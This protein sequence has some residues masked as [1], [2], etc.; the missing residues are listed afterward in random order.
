MPMETNQ[1]YIEKYSLDSEQE[2]RKAQAELQIAV[3]MNI[4]S[5]TEFSAVEERRVQKNETI[6]KDL[7][8]GKIVYG[9]RYYTP[10]MYLQYELTRFK[11]DFTTYQG[12]NIGPYPLCQITEEEKRTFYDENRDLFTRYFGDSF[13]YEEVRMI[14]EKRL[15]EKE[16]EK[17][18]Q[19]I[20]R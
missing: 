12:K 14:I 4:I 15:K 2:L 13:G 11:L 19:D 16:Y 6:K 8:E 5:S 17:I 20:L 10:V 1:V 3:W 9:V 18:V 7:A